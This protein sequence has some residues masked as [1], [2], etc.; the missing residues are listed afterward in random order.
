MSAELFFFLVIFIIGNKKQTL[1]LFKL[2]GVKMII[3]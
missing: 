2:R 1:H 3:V